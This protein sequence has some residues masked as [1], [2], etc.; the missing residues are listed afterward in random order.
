MKHSELVLYAY[1]IWLFQIRLEPEQDLRRTCFVIP[2][3]VLLMKLT[4]STMLS[5]AMKSIGVGAQS[6]LGGTTF[7]P[8][9]YVWKINKLPEF[10]TIL[11]RKLTKFP[12][13][14]WFLPENSRILH[15]ISPK[16]FPRI[17]GGHVPPY[18]PPRLLRLWQK[19]HCSTVQCFLCCITGC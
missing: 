19:R 2:E 11:A 10:Y 3:Q 7:L 1:W 4:A 17:L 14:T 13:C 8:E 12:K 6:T 5:A 15:K 16:N 18:P 9:K